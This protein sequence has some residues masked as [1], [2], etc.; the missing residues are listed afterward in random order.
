M[1]NLSGE[2][3]KQLTGLNDLVHV[4]YKGAGPGITDLVS[5]HIPMMTPN[6]T[7]QVLAFHRAG[8]IRILA[9][10][11][12]RAAHG[13][14]RHSDRDRGRGAGHD[15]PALPRLVRAGRHPQADRR[16]YRR[17]HACG[18]GGRGF[19][20]GVDRLRGLEAIPDSNSEKA[21]ALHRRRKS[22][23]G[24]R[25]SKP[26]ASRWS[27]YRDRRQAGRNQLTVP[28]SR[29][30][31]NRCNAARSTLLVEASGSSSTNQTKRGC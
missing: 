7:G 19:S 31:P 5:G 2:L 12:A 28:A 8:K 1:S 6:V 30:S 25:W 3:F 4:P 21:Q 10:N 27:E 18:D 26:R 14:A 22:R 15:R 16:S 9:V 13:G 24:A 11:G 29:S 17:S 23:A 20:E